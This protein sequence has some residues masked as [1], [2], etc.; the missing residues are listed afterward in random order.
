MN[1][2]VKKYLNTSEYSLH[3]DLEL[4]ILYIGGNYQDGKYA[5]TVSL[6][7]SFQQTKNNNC[8]VYTIPLGY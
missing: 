7:A 5:Q 3:T 4:S 6:L 8:I 1:T 2:F